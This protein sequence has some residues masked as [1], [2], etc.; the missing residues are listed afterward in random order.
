MTHGETRSCDYGLPDGR[1]VRAYYKEHSDGTWSGAF[2]DADRVFV[3]NEGGIPKKRYKRNPY[4]VYRKHRG[5][6]VKE[7]KSALVKAELALVAA[8]KAIKTNR[9]SVTAER[10]LKWDSGSET[11]MESGQPLKND[12]RELVKISLFGKRTRTYLVIGRIIKP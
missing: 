1:K 3:I 4:E 11:G 8:G 10:D 7:V 6:T 2:D 5:E 12:T 9:P